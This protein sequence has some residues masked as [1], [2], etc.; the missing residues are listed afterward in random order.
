MGQQFV[1]MKSEFTL[2]LHDI[3]HVA[4]HDNAQLQQSLPESTFE[5]SA[6]LSSSQIGLRQLFFQASSM[7]PSYVLEVVKL[8]E[9]VV[10]DNAK[11]ADGSTVD[12][13]QVSVLLLIRVSHPEISHRN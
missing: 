3:Q 10:C 9:T 8:L 11:T 7:S 1:T 13:S 4:L 2:K 12:I 6:T 5:V